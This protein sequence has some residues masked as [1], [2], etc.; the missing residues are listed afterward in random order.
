MDTTV[1]GIDVSKERLDVSVQPAGTALGYSRDAAGIE[2]LIGMLTS[3]APQLIAV[4]ATGGFEAP[5]L[6]SS[7]PPQFFFARAASSH[8]RLSV[9]VQPRA[10]RGS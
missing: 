6:Q 1:V 7:W 5:L 10:S 2:L 4:E 8:P 3:A 9:S